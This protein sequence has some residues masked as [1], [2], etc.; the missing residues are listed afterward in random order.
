M[1]KTI[2][3]GAIGA[4]ALVS[5]PLKKMT[6]MREIYRE[7]GL[8]Q[9]PRDANKYGDNVVDIH[10][11]Q[12]AQFFG[13][14]TVGTP[15]VELSVI[16][17]TGSSNLWVPGKDCADC[18]NHPR[19]DSSAS[20]SYVKNGSA[21]NIQYGSGPVSG[22]LSQDNVNVGGVTVKS[23]TFSEIQDVSGLGLAYKVGKF[24]GILGLAF[25]R[26][27]VDGIPPVFKSMIDQGLVD[28][29]LFAFYLAAGKDGS[30]DFGGIEESHYTGDIKYVPLSAET[31]W[32]IK[33]DGMSIKGQSV[34]TVTN[35]IVDSGT[36]LL[37][38]PKADVKAIAKLVGATPFLHG[39][40]LI[41]CDKVDTAPDLDITLGGNVYTLTAKDYIINAGGTC[42]FGMVGLDTPQPMWILG[43]PFMRKFYTIFDYGN[44]RLGFATAA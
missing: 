8:M 38:G 33:M 41:K 2:A 37:A 28:E 20:S 26:I 30:L 39:E 6:T 27:S 35:A 22:F 24:D 9:V 29:P 5:I 15:G 7:N 31:Y 10:N 44:K 13:S 16:F 4:S 18:G 43:D 34:T 21:F 14:I 19:Y 40:F 42:L 12:D 3:L 25:Q 1:L 11:Y 23:A 36:S 17:D 32:A